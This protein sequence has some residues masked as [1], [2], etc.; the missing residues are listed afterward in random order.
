MAQLEWQAREE[1]GQMVRQR[2]SSLTSL[3]MT[4]MPLEEIGELLQAT[5]HRQL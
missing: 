3:G 5:Q 2:L 1:L 4:M